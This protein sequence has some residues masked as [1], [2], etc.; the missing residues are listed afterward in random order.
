MRLDD[1]GR[2][3][4]CEGDIRT[5]LL[6]VACCVAASKTGQSQVV[7]GKLNVS[8]KP[9]GI[10]C[11]RRKREQVS[12]CCPIRARLPEEGIGKQSMLPKKETQISA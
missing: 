1:H 6:D 7:F 2:G 4:I 5:R 11:T 3:Q 8:G 10:V 12:V 9:I